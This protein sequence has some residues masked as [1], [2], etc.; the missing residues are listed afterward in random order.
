MHIGRTHGE[1]RLGMSAEVRTSYTQHPENDHLEKGINAICQL[2]WPSGDLPTIG[3]FFAL[4]LHRA[5]VSGNEET[6]QL[7][8]RKSCSKREPYSFDHLTDKS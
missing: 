1:C 7:N 5:P 4:P 3:F 8:L 2:P 6:T